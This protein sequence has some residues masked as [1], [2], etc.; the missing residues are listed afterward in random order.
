MG[1]GPAGIGTALALSVLPQVSIGVVERGEIGQTFADW[2][3][4]QRFLTPSF[5]GNGFGA[6]DLNAIHPETS[7]AFSLGVDYPDG[8]QYA[9]YLAA[10]AQ[11]FEVPVSTGTE[12]TAVRA[13]GQAF[14]VD[15]SRG[16]IR[17]RTLVWAGGE[18]TEPTAPAVTNAALAVHSS[19]S[20]AWQ[21]PA[22]SDRLVVI[23]GYESGIDLACHH[24]QRGSRVTVLDHQHP[25][26]AGAGSDP[27]YQLAPRTRQRLDRA[28]GTGRL[29]LARGRAASIEQDRNGYLVR[30]TGGARHPSS[31][32]PVLATGFG[33][34]LGPVAGLFARRSD[35]WPLLTAD[36]ES[37]VTPGL[38]LNGPALRHDDLRFCFVYKFRQRYAQIA[39]TIGDRFSRDT[40]GLEYWREAGM[41]TDDLSCCGVSCAC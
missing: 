25:W 37:T 35:G 27:S 33:P 10:V 30:T 40:S 17:A 5:T 29:K 6:T 41:W 34:G 1:A 38:F 16:P 31:A 3:D 18:F 12:V 11:H 28:M 36:D 14:R 19:D 8:A 39:R 20:R 13:D 23:G 26:N 4:K 24:V 2:P 7:P 21:A 9:R 15:T 22:H 32:Q